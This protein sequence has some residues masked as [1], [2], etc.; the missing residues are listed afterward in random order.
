MVELKGRPETR[1]PLNSREREILMGFPPGHLAKM[2]KKEAE[3]E[4]DKSQQEV[5]A[6]CCHRKL[7]PHW[8]N[9]HFGRHCH[10]E[11]GKE[12][13]DEGHHKNAR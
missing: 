12:G 6:C 8:C 4:L 3:T 2:H 1:R 11:L 9:G 7:V 10:V 5:Q 13:G